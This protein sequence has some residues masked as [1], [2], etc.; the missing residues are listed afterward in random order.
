MKKTKT[1]QLTLGAA[2][3]AVFLILHIL[4]PGG[5]KSLQG[6]LLIVTFLPVTVYS[7]SCGFRKALIMVIAGMVLSGL[8]L[9]PEVFLSF[10]APAL[11]IGLAAGLTYG[12]CRRLTV[13]L[14]IS[15]MFLLQ[16]IGEAVIYYLMININLVDTYIWAVGMVYQRIPSQLLADPL[17]SRFLEDFLLC[18]VPCLA[19]LVSGAKGVLSFMILNM[20]HTRLESVMGPVPDDKFTRQTQFRSAGISI[21]YLCVICIC[22]VM[23]V[24]PFLGVPYHFLAAAFAAM[25]LFAAVL[26]AYYFYTNRIR[27]QEDRQKR[28]VYSFLLM[29]TLPISIFAMP[30]LEIRLLKSKNNS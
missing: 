19:I 9:P 23:A 10:A 3:L 12:K 7:L 6:M 14:I 11:L 24:L 20:L 15:A 25:G 26:Y 1:A 29:V 22:T 21:A 30:L 2:L 16:N 5:Q 27:S 13:I 8:L 17:F 28:L 18:I 4:I